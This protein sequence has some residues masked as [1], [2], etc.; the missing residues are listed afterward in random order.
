MSMR[1]NCPE[2]GSENFKKN[3][4]THNGK[5]NHQCKD[6]ERELVLNPE[7]EVISQETKE[8]A[9]KM[10]FMIKKYESLP[11][12]L[13]FKEVKKEKKVVF[14]RFEAE[15]DEMWSIDFSLSLL[16]KREKSKR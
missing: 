2:C 8:L 11:D 7:K 4:H 9:E 3:G 10:Q 5:Q 14:F 6:C 15:V 16:R 13:N 1:T 12:D